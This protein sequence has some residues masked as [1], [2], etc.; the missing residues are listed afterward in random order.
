MDA[1]AELFDRERRRALRARA[2]HGFADHAFLKA[3]MV[4]DIA[5]RVEATGKPFGSVLDLGAHDGR[6]GARIGAEMT[7]SVDAA[8]AFAPTLVADEDRLPFADDSFDLIVSAGSLH[9]VND[10]PGALIQVRRALRSGGMFIA[11]FVAGETLLQLRHDLIE[12]EDAM[13][14]RV[15]VRVAPMIDVQGAAGLLQRGGFVSPVAEIDTVTVRYRGL[16]ALLA[17]LR[18]MGEGNVLASR[19]ALRRDVLAAAGARFAARA[20]S[21][22]KTPVPVQIITLTGWKAS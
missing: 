2:A 10:L 8:V 15:A 16:M 13:T 5:A 14:G 11:A 18:G 4:E 7:V 3:A 1:N 22:G 6:L 19:M 21:D 9:N 20:D 12:V 17:D